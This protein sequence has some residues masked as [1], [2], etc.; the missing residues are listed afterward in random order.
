ME[1]NQVLEIQTSRLKKTYIN[2]LWV[3]PII[4]IINLVLFIKMYFISILYY[5]FYI[6]CEF[7]YFMFIFIPI[8]PL[9]LLKKNLIL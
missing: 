1:D 7:I 8:Y 4:S 6:I 2:H 9:E 3:F 5:S